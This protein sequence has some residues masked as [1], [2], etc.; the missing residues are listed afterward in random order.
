MSGRLVGEV[1]RY[2]PLDLTLLDRFVLVALAERAHDKDRTARHR[3]D[4]GN[5]ATALASTEPSVRNA[6]GRLRK[7]GLIVPLIEKCHRGTAQHYYLPPMHE[8]TRKAT[9]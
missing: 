5:I 2:A 8:G 7:R 9:H 3:A 6:L 4:A 1:L